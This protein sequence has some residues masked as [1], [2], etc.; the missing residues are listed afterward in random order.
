MKEI[1]G[2]AARRMIENIKG[3]EKRMTEMK[4]VTA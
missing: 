1:D 2:E 4:K 3:A